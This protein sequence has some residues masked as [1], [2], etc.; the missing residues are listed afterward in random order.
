MAT[1]ICLI[2]FPVILC[3]LLV[4]FQVI[5]NKALNGPN[6]QCGCSCVPTND[7]SVCKDMCGIEYSTP[8]QAIFC[9]IPKPPHWPA[10]LQV[11]SF[12]YRA[13]DEHID[14]FPGLPDISCRWWGT[15]PTSFLYTGANQSI[16]DGI[17]FIQLINKSQTNVWDIFL[18]LIITVSFFAFAGI[19]SGFFS[20]P[21]SLNTSDLLLTL[22]ELVPVRSHFISK[23]KWVY[24]IIYRFKNNIYVSNHFLLFKGRYTNNLAASREHVMVYLQA[25]S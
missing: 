10:V 1:N 6:H 2:G 21:S 24:E 15:C 19:V 20:T 5:I 7:T 17:T 23:S 18:R 8:S 25:T 9:A 22:G 14:E 3:A 16:G 12:P 11:P 13:V 4:I